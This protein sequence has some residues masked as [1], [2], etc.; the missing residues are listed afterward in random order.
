MDDKNKTSDS[1][2][3]EWLLDLLKNVLAIIIAQFIANI[4]D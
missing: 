4:F 1:K 3:K 2:I